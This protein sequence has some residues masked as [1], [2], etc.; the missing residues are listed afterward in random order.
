M[1]SDQ[2]WTDGKVTF[3]VRAIFKGVFKILGGKDNI[4]IAMSSYPVS[5]TYQNTNIHAP[6]KDLWT[7]GFMSLAL[8][9]FLASVNYS[10]SIQPNIIILA[11]VSYKLHYL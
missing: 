1:S 6:I 11:I 3:K 5:S 10:L 8:I 9:V 2:L 4:N 7:Y